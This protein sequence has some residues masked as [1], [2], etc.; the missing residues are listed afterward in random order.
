MEIKI[1]L[2]SPTDGHIHSVV[3]NE[4]ATPE[5][6]IGKTSWTDN[7]D[8]LVIYQ[9]AQPE[10]V[11]PATGQPIPAV[12]EKTFVLPDPTDG[13]THELDVVPTPYRRTFT[14]KEKNMYRRMAVDL[15][16][17]AKSL[18]YK[19]IKNADR[20]YEFYIGGDDAWQDQILSVKKAKGQAALTINKIKNIVNAITGH[21]IQDMKD[22]IYKPMTDA[23]Q[24]K[25]DLL[26]EVTKIVLEHSDFTT[27]FAEVVNDLVI[28]GRGIFDVSIVTD[29]NPLGD[30]L[31][32]HVEYD[33]CFMGA[34]KDKGLRDLLCKASH[35]WYSRYSLLQKVPKKDREVVDNLRFFS[36]EQE[37]QSENILMYDDAPLSTGAYDLSKKGEE[38]VDHV[39]KKV[40]VISVQMRVIEKAD[41]GIHSSGFIFTID[42]NQAEE[43]K[44]VLFQLP[45][46]EFFEKDV[47]KTILCDVACEE[48]LLRIEENPG[49]M[50]TIAAAY[51]FKK[52]DKIKGEVYDLQVL[53]EENNLVRSKI[54]DQI[55]T[56]A[57]RGY[58]ITQE[59]FIN[60][61]EK[62]AFRKG[63]NTDGGLFQLKDINKPPLK[64][65]SGSIDPALVNHIT[66][67][68]NEFGT[69]SGV[70][71][72]LLGVGPNNGSNLVLQS[73]KQASLVKLQYIFTGMDIALKRLGKILLKLYPFIF[74]GERVYNMLY[75]RA[76]DKNKPIT[77]GGST[78]GSYSKEEVANAWDSIQ[79]SDYD[80]NPEVSPY[81]SSQRERNF[82]SFATLGS[83][84]VPGIDGRM[85]IELSDL[86]PR[87]K[88]KAM[89]YATQTMNAQMKAEEQKSNVEIQKTQIAAESREK[90]E[91]AK[92]SQKDQI[93]KQELK[94][95]AMDLGDKNAKKP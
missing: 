8:H 78:I 45:D 36:F 23:S 22:I 18:N 69:V 25:C 50:I 84:G 58:F 94:L 85:L 83:Q 57:G 51:A 37:Y 56:L 13:H 53:S 48:L 46:F 26:N 87:L 2:P 64:D 88:E 66:M 4:Q 70:N 27:A 59:T 68:Q 95:K 16:R 29:E 24:M 38:W 75:A 21:M 80:V 47:E 10:G 33:E 1:A 31:V 14:T 40:K 41:F 60:D 74:T 17:E 61:A 15:Y 52:K 7:H 63:I 91:G 44:Q 9:P 30:I 3:I 86:P 89:E 42:P 67:I 81:S 39:G 73:N 49:D 62:D 82:T 71:A 65:V 76:D 6:V 72:E 55:K 54:T 19:Y 34:H 28:T 32:T 79:F 12:P 90:V 35:A 43:I 5:G 20:A 77:V 93:Q 92:L 11:D